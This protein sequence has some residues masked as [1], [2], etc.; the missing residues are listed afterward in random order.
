MAEAID[1]LALNQPR[2]VADLSC[3]RY[4]ALDLS[5]AAA[6][7]ERAKHL[8]LMRELLPQVKKKSARLPRSSETNLVSGPAS[9]LRKVSGN[10]EETNARKKDRIV[11]GRE[12]KQRR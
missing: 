9:T 5:V 6:G 2:R 8:E 4:K 3:E 10:T 11:P 1:R 12:S 7:W